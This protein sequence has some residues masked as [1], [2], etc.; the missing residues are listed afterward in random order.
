MDCIGRR[1]A[2]SPFG[3][4]KVAVGQTMNLFP[5]RRRV[6][7]EKHATCRKTAADYRPTQYSN[8]TVDRLC[9]AL[10]DRDAQ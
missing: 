2:N 8:V 3:D 5:L 7:F 9:V 4:I 6:C 1:F 10:A